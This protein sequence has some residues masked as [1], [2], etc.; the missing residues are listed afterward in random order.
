[1]KKE[2]VEMEYVRAKGRCGDTCRIRG[3]RNVT[4]AGVC[5]MLGKRH[6]ATNKC[7]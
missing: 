1:M 5:G 7:R 6:R 2:L 3:R 4:T